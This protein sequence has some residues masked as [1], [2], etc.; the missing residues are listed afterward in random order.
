MPLLGSIASTPSRPPTPGRHS[1]SFHG[2]GSSLFLLIL[3]NVLLTIVTL[4]VY[5][6]WAATERRKYVW[7]NVEFHGQRFIFGGTGL[8][9]FIGY[10]KVLV[11]YAVFLGVPML[12]RQISPSLAI[13]VQVAFV[14]G[15]VALIPF[16]VYG[17]RA[18]LLSRSTWRGIHFSMQPGAGPFVRAFLV[19]Y[20]LTVVTLGLYMPV[21]LNKLRKI[22]TDRSRF[23]NHAFRYDGDDFEVW[24]MSMKGLL[25]S[26]VTL[27]IYYFW[28]RANL[29]RYEVEHTHFGQ[30]KG[31]LELTGG[32]V[33][34]FTMT[35]LLGTTLTLGLAFPWLATYVLRSVFERTSLEGDIDFAAIT[36]SEVRGNAA[37]DGLA[38]VMDVGLSI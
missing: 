15:L 16:A 34:K 12:V 38:D 35:Y 7:Q 17:S 2:T 21:W 6:P 9:L 18:Y 29:S 13:A 26:I 20:L 23:G 19:G 30:A 5:A 22:I 10:L 3:K 4:G 1:L 28:F 37:G 27:G 31:R 11:G 8:E 36:Q 14:L 25:L 32:D 33:F 24:V